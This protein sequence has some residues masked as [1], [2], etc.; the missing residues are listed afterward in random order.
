M[1]PDI[2]KDTR[3]F[4]LRNFSEYGVS[5]GGVQKEFDVGLKV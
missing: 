3:R 5:A 2:C 1:N 4:F